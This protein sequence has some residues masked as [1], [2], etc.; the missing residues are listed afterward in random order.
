MMATN[1]N[2]AFY[3]NIKLCLI[4]HQTTVIDL[5]VFDICTSNVLFCV[6]P[7]YKNTYAVGGGEG[8]MPK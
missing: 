2:E 7:K 4:S 8:G 5:E 3:K 1:F 6:M